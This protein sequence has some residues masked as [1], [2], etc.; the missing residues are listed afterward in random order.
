M[1]SQTD[2][3]PRAEDPAGSAG[4]GAGAVRRVDSVTL[5]GRQ[6]EVVIVHRGQEY[7][8]RVTKSDKLI[9]TK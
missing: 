9:L 2:M 5:L 8:L 3:V 4:D 6:R 7:R 1:A